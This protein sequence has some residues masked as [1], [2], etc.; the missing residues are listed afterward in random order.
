MASDVIESQTGC[1]TT[2]CFE[3][4]GHKAESYDEAMCAQNII[5]A[6]T[7]ILF[8]GVLATPRVAKRSLITIGTGS[9]ACI[10]IEALQLFSHGKHD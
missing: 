5:S 6:I 2:T 10:E 9:H 3:S 4:S 7:I 8:S 1:Q